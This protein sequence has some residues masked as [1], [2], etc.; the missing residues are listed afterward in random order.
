MYTKPTHSDMDNFILHFRHFRHGSDVVNRFVT[1]DG[2]QRDKNRVMTFDSF[3]ST[4]ENKE[5]IKMGI[6]NQQATLLPNH[7]IIYEKRSSVSAELGIP[8][9]LYWRQITNELILF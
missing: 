8:Y 2:A 6:L 1:T 3:V 5:I 9:S 7:S 4:T